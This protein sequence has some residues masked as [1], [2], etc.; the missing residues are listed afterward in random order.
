MTT[1]WSAKTERP[2]MTRA[3]YR[4]VVELDNE[5]L[6]EAFAGRVDAATAAMLASSLVEYGTWVRATPL[7]DPCAISLFRSR[8][9]ASG[10]WRFTRIRAQGLLLQWTGRL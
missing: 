7:G 2:E 9:L 10:R 1:Y 8:P 6:I 5:A 3:L 4:P